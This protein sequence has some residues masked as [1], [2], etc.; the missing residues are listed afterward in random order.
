M[1]L[2]AAATFDGDESAGR[3]WQEYTKA[4]FG[5]RQLAWSKG[6]RDL[7]QLSRERTDAEIAADVGEQCRVLAVVLGLHQW[8]CVL[9]NDLRGE[10]LQVAARGGTAAVWSFLQAIGAGSTVEDIV[11]ARELLER[12]EL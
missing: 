3:L 2:L 4:F 11:S 1:D 12:G 9:G 8:R 5:R 6:L 10:L 7:L